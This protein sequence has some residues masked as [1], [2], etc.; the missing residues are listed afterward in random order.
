MRT[1]KYFELKAEAEGTWSVVATGTDLPLTIELEKGPS[2]LSFPQYGTA[3]EWA[4]QLNADPDK[5][6]IIPG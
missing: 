4:R 5:F 1:Q 6:K 3:V 2:K